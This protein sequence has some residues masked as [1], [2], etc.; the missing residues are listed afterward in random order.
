MTVGQFDYPKPNR[1]TYRPS[2]PVPR[3]YIYADRIAQDY[4][5]QYVVW[6]K[7]TNDPA[8]VGSNRW[9]DNWE[10]LGKYL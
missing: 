10:L 8:L 5:S 3:K 6:Q 9:A 1:V 4:Y 7:Q 2:Y